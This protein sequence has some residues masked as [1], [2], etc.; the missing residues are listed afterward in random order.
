MP[1]VGD[2]QSLIIRR[3]KASI[4]AVGNQTHAGISVTQSFG[5]TIAGVIIY[6][7][8]FIAIVAGRVS[9]NRLNRL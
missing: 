6:H 3:A 7:D 4:I 5:A 1:P 2:L 9:I 8:N